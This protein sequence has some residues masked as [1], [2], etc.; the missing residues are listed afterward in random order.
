MSF[1]IEGLVAAAHTPFHVDGSLNLAAVE[2]QAEH[3]LKDRVTTVFIGGST[4]E[5][6]S[7]SLDERRGLAIRWI[8]VARRHAPLRVIVHVGSN[9]IADAKVLAAQAQELGAAAVSALAPS[10]FKPRSVQVLVECCQEIAA[11]A[12]G[13]PFYFYDIPSLTGVALPMSEF[14]ALA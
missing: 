7:L 2:R 13:L 4:G 8:E 10:Y 12:P 9:C 11:A 6:H 1:R 3:L 5:C 14:L